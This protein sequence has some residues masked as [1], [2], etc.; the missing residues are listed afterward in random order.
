MKSEVDEIALQGIEFWSTV[1]DEESDL[2]IEA[3]EVREGVGEGEEGREGGGG[4]REEGGR[5]EGGREG[6]CIL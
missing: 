4:G 3:I 2:A 5:G 1:C 6:I